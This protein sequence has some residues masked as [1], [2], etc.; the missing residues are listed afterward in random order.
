[1]PT[2]ERQNRVIINIKDLKSQIL[3]LGMCPWANYSTPLS[4]HFFIS[5]LEIIFTSLGCYE[6]MCESDLGTFLALHSSLLI[7]HYY[8][9]AVEDAS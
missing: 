2:L 6:I 4:L 7:T 3:L 9:L 5:K 8:L 1:M